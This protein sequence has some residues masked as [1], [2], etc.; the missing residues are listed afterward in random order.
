MSA[1]PSAEDAAVADQRWEMIDQDVRESPGVAAMRHPGSDLSE[2]QQRRP[3]KLVRAEPATLP[4][5]QRRI[6]ELPGSPGLAVHLHRCETVDRPTGA[7]LWIHG[8]GYVMG[9]AQDG[10]DILDHWASTFRCTVVSVDYRLAPEAPYPAA[11]D[12]CARALAWLHEQS[13]ALQ[14]DPAHVGVGGS[15]AGG[16]LAAAVA[17]WNR[18]HDQLPLAFQLLLYPMLDHRA[19]T[20]SMQWSHLAVWSAAASRVG[21]SSYLRGL[22]HDEVPA[23]ASPALADDLAGLPETCVLACAMDGFVDEDV[24]YAQRLLHDGVRTD[25]F[26]YAGAPHGVLQLAPTSRVGRKILA[27]MDHWLADRLAV[28][29]E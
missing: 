26:V 28:R 17:L 15:S 19:T 1:E 14:I 18:D 20:A 6:V 2:F 22:A 24:T 10:A 3:P 27:D 5:V 13:G 29:D 21:W 7:L 11:V 4:G 16:G 25:L 12:D 8:G 23:Y 9:S